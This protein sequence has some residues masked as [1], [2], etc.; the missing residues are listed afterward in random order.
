MVTFLKSSGGAWND[1]YGDDDPEDYKE[2]V[3]N[4]ST[5]F[6]CWT[7]GRRHLLGKKNHD[8]YKL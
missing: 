4:I 8:H 7:R 6:T 5:R 1:E 3:Q 2:A